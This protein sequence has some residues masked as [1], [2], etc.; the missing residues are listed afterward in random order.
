MAGR[1]TTPSSSRIRRTSTARP[2]TSDIQKFEWVTLEQYKAEKRFLDHYPEDFRT[3]WSPRDDV[4]SM[5]V[6]LL[7]S[8]Q[9]SLVLNM[10]GYDDEILDGIIR[11]KILTEHVY[12]QMSLDKTQ[13]GGRAESGLLKKWRNDARGAS[14]AIGTSSVGH[15]ISHLKICIV[16][17]IYTI[18]GSTNWSLSGES[19]QDNELTL[20][21]NAVIA[22]EARAVLDLNHDWMLKEM[23]EARL[24]ARPASPRR[25]A[26]TAPAAVTR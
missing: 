14:I 7:S 25:T 12:V 8:T 21:R 4:H 10:Y 18:K 20:S 3:F 9:H 23:A 2:T 24:A 22:A 13:A 15:A 17:G 6:S 16:D 5:L 19:K 11:K 1:R 26:R